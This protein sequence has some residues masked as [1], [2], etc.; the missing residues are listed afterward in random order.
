MK[1]SY[2]SKDGAGALLATR[3]WLKSSGLFLKITS[4]GCD[5]VYPDRKKK[6]STRPHIYLFV[7]N[8]I[9]EYTEKANGIKN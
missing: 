2:A 1:I 5:Y 3:R 8:L 7:K 4:I 9:T 6:K